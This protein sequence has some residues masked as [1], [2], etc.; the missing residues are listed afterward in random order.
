VPARET[1]AIGAEPTERIAVRLE[2]HGI[3]VVDAPVSCGV[4]D[5]ES[6]APAAAQ[7]LAA[8]IGGA[9]LGR[10]REAEAT[11]GGAAD[12]ALIAAAHSTPIDSSRR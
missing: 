10:W 4:P 5:A 9:A 1:A 2:A 12:V 6:G 8:P 3:A 11:L 7:G